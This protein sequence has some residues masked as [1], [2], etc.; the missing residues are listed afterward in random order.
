MIR[1]LSASKATHTLTIL[2]LLMTS[3]SSVVARADE[4][5]KNTPPVK[6]DHSKSIRPT[7]GRPSR[8]GIPVDV[9]PRSGGIVRFSQVS[10]T[11]G[12]RTK[13]DDVLKKLAA[14]GSE[15]GR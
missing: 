8:D 5:A 3:L 13:A 4:P 11:H 12:D 9:R 15:A 7:L 1:S 2:L 6:G 14:I 10:R